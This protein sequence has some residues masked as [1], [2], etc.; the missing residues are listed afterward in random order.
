MLWI[1]IAG[2]LVALLAGYVALYS[3]KGGTTHR[4]AGRVFAYAMFTMT[5]SSA[6]IAALLRPNPGNVL[7]AATTFYLVST[8]WLAVRPGIHQAKRRSVALAV[9]GVATAL[10]G[11]GLATM[12]FDTPRNSIGG[13]PAVAMVVFA[14]LVALASAADFRVLFWTQTAPA[15]RLTRHIWRMGFALWIATASFFFGQADKFPE[16]I[17]QTG[18][19]GLPVAAVALTLMYWLARQALIG[20][21]AKRGTLV[22]SRAQ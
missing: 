16:A 5:V 14:S 19:L 4:S 8:G 12:A 9:F 1:H 17:R 22:P 3:K 18:L 13:I 11:A 6:I 20:R 21:R 2:G 7:A 10:Y 15:A